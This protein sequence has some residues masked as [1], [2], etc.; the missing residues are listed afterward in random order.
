MVIFFFLLCIYICLVILSLVWG[1]AQNKH[2]IVL[3]CI[4]ALSVLTACLIDKEGLPDYEQYVTY[5]SIADTDII[6]LEP[7]F[8]LISYLIKILFNGDV[9]WGFAIY[10]V[11]GTIIKVFAIKRLTSLWFLSFALYIG[12]YWTYY[13]LIQIRAG[14]AAAFFL[15]AL[16]PLFERDIKRFLFYSLC[17]ICFHYSAIMILPLWFIKGTLKNRYFYMLLI[18]ICILLYFCHV[19]FMSVMSLLPIPYIQNKIETYSLVAQLGSDRGM[20]T[21]AEYN[22]FI[23][24]YL[25]KAFLAIL[26]WLF[27]KRISIYNKYAVLLLKIYTI[28]VALLWCLPSIPIAATRCSEFLSIVQVIL[29][30]LFVY[31]ARQRKIMYVVPILY[32]IV[33]IYWNASSFL[34]DI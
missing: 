30:P 28:G 8:I 15:M 24:W 20:I 4:A 9:F 19:D 14:V 32:G 34:F 2:P 29:I 11:L 22:P 23:P 26:M 25:L 33:W 1:D 31:A 6:S 5:F 10:L 17:A 27:V 13:E 16:K 21:A 3:F 12:S 18:P 7:T